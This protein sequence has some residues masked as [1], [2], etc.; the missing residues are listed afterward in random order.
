MNLEQLKAMAKKHGLEVD[1][2][3]AGAGKF[4]DVEV[5]M[6]ADYPQLNAFIAD[7]KKAEPVAARMVALRHVTNTDHPQLGK[8][9]IEIGSF[10]YE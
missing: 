2:G 8:P 7:Y 1:P 9:Y 6:G 5:G 3:H 4:R 10:W